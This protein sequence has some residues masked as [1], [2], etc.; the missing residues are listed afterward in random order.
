MIRDSTVDISCLLFSADQGFAQEGDKPITR[1]PESMTEMLAYDVVL[2]GDVDPRQFTD[3]QLQLVSDFVARKGG[4]FGMIA[5]PR[6]SPLAFRNTPIEAI[7]PVNIA[8]VQPD[9][10]SATFDQGFRP[11]LTKEGA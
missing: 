9:D 11:V 3:R 1:F 8:H 5:G 4:G 2:F 10:P 6:W 7:L